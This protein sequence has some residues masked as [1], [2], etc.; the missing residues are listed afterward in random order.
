MAGVQIAQFGC[1]SHRGRELDATHSLQGQYSGIK[2]PVG[3]SLTQRYLQSFTLRQPIL[4]R[5]AVFVERQLL[6]RAVERECA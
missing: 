1:Q 5:T 6:P 4:D 2:P 3:N